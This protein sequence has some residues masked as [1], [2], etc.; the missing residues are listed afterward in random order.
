MKRFERILRRMVVLPGWLVTVIAIPSFALVIYVLANHLTGSPLSYAGYAASA[1]ALVIVAVNVRR[2]AVS[3][4]AGFERYPLVQRIRD[5]QRGQRF[6]TEPMY[7]AEIALYAGLLIN[8]AYAVIKMVSGVVFRSIW[9]GALAGYYLMLSAIRFALLNH[10]RRNPVGQNL[11]SE[12]KRCRL[13]GIILLMMNQAL[14][15]VVIL[16]VRRSSGAEYPGYLIYIMAMYTFYAV[17]NAVRNVIKFRLSG[18]PVLSAAKSISLIAALVSMLSLETA[19]LSQFGSETEKSYRQIMTG[20]TGFA[21]CA[22]VLAMAIY[23][24]VHSTRQI[25]GL[26]RGELT[27]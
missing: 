7:R 15:A 16:V 25:R 10:T 8:L 22:I 26:K 11:L 19:M 24:I 4:R 23:M 17:I 18:S 2:M 3:L 1:Y 5:S 21:V 12:W 13:C 27:R 6:L 14:S 20:C 9:F